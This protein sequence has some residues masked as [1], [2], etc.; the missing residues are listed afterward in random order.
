MPEKHKWHMRSPCKRQT[1]GS[2]PASG[3]MLRR[4]GGGDLAVNQYDCEFDSHPEH[5]FPRTAAYSKE[6]RPRV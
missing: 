2:N 1:A 5:Q 6:V 3:S 4:T